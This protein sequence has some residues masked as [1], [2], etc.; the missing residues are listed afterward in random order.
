MNY[1][2]KLTY[3]GTNY[4]GWQIQNNVPTIQ[5]AMETAVKKLF[6]RDFTVHGCS[7]TDAGVHA[8][9][10]VCMIKEAPD[11][12]PSKLPYALNT[13][14]PENI[15]VLD[16]TCVPESFHPRFS[17]L[18]KEYIYKIYSSRI[19]N[20]FMNN[21]AYMYKRPLDEI[22]CN[23]IAKEFVGT[24][25][26]CAFMASGSAIT[27]TVRTIYSF[28]VYSE[29]GIIFFKVCGDGFL[30][31]MVRIMVGTILNSFEGKLK[32][33]IK[34]IILSKNRTL[35]GQTMPAYALYLNK[36]FYEKDLFS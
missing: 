15:A 21:K 24:Y 6:C 3:S 25:D 33:P 13:Y 17:A 18:K 30:Y 2:I 23:E 8:L 19:R 16:A 27:D 35:A 36:V 11:F 14:L 20:P 1:A 29:G 28:D 12:D 10:Y 9:E 5:G 26:F 31:N 34:D 7:R 22:K 4:C 32:L